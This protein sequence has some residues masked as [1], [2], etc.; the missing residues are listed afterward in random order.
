MLENLLI[1]EVSFC[2]NVQGHFKKKNTYIRRNTFLHCSQIAIAPVAPHSQ[3]LKSLL[4]KFLHDYGLI[5]DVRAYVTQIDSS[6]LIPLHK[7][8]CSRS[9]KERNNLIKNGKASLL[10]AVLTLYEPDSSE[11]LNVRS[12]MA[13]YLQQTWELY[14][15]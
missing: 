1:L 6:H 3:T 2:M 13:Q 9:L 5:C 10:N 14:A 12:L 15:I 4:A 8:A 7:C 11:V